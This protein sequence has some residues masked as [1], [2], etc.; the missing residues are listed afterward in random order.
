METDGKNGTMILD[1]FDRANEYRY[2]PEA[3]IHMNDDADWLAED[4]GE[5][6]DRFD[7][8]QVASC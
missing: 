1:S 5:Y 7:T 6:V 2:D 8:G 4:E 3:E